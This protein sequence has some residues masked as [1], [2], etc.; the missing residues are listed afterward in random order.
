MRRPTDDC[1]FRYFPVRFEKVILQHL[2]RAQELFI[3][4]FWQSMCCPSSDKSGNENL[5]DK[6]APAFGLNLIVK[7]M[8]NYRI[9]CEQNERA[10]IMSILRKYNDVVIDNVSS[11]SFAITIERDDAEVFYHNL[12]DE[13]DREVYIYR[14]ERDRVK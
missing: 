1:G 9:Y 4:P 6:K 2:N 11:T 8:E 14:R 7:S 10:E 5:F 3:N 13:I 12:L